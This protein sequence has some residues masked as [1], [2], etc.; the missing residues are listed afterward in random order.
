MQFC[1]LEIRNVPRTY[2]A[3]ARPK[4]RLSSI[5]GGAN[6]NSVP[7]LAVNSEVL[8][9]LVVDLSLFR[10]AHGGSYACAM[11]FEQFAELGAAAYFDW[12]GD[13][14]GPTSFFELRSLRFSSVSRPSL[15]D[16]L[17]LSIPI[18][19]C[20]Y[21]QVRRPKWTFSQAVESGQ[22]GLIIRRS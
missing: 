21:R 9:E 10:R 4:R 2:T 16:K 17:C 5:D 7:G 6:G 15:V 20:I 14:Q 13:G 11:V 22:I 8:E 3:A 19:D 1:L 12:P 18:D